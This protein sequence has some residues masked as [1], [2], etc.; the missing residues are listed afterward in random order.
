MNG[1]RHVESTT[2]VRDEGLCVNIVSQRC[3]RCGLTA[4]RSVR[5]ADWIQHDRYIIEDL[6]WMLYRGGYPEPSALGTWDD[7]IA[8]ESA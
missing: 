6:A 1:C 2:E 4:T 8:R 3:T 5:D 7:W